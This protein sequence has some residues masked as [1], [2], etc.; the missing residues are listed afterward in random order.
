MIQRKQTLYLLLAIV[1]TI[2]T[3]ST[4]TATLTDDGVVVERVYNLM[5]IRHSGEVSY[6]VCPL[7]LILMVAATIGVYAIFMFKQRLRQA[8]WCLAAVGLY[9][10]WYVALAVYSKSLAPD[11]LHFHLSWHAVLPGIS[12]ILFFMARKAILADEKLVRAADR[13]R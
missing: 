1:L 6:D 2:V 13:I 3:L 8:A 4:Q 5:R 11:A 9:L 7:F 12:C 10:V